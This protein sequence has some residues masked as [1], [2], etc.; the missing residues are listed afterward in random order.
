MHGAVEMEVAR[1]GRW[2]ILP[3]LSYFLTDPRRN[4][5]SPFRALTPGYK[6][7]SSEVT[8]PVEME[9]ARLGR[10]H[11]EI[12]MI[13]AETNVVGEKWKKPA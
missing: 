8:S 1:L 4:G 11:T 6:Q 12:I 3:L 7:P 10:W 13:S 2:H 9:V 5:S